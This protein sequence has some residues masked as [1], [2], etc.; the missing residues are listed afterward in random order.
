M[1]NFITSFFSFSKIEHC[2]VATKYIYVSS[3]CLHSILFLDTIVYSTKTLMFSLKIFSLS[4]HFYPMYL[5]VDLHLSYLG[6]V[7][8]LG[9]VN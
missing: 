8:V 1:Y 9:H 3:K 7:E 6:L 2:S 4:Q 5:G